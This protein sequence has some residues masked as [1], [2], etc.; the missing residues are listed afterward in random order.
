MIPL[1]LGVKGKSISIKKWK[2]FINKVE[3][4]YWTERIILPDG[5]FFLL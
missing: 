4:I 3:F 1:K 5:K 2:K